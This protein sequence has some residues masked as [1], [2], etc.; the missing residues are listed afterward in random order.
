M[1][2]SVDPAAQEFAI[3]IRQLQ[4]RVNALEPVVRFTG[5]REQLHDQA[6]DIPSASFR[7]R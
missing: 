3:E 2:D 6:F 1:S 5:L 4:Q 7:S